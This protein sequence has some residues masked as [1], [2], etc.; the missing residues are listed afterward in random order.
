MKLGIS[1]RNKKNTNG[2][3]G[4][5]VS[6]FVLTAIIFTFFGM[7]VTANL[8]L[9]PKSVAQ[10]S[11]NIAQTGLFPIIDRNG[12]Q[13]SPFV[14]VVEQVQDAVV[15]VSAKAKN[16]D[17]PWWHQGT[18]FS[19]SSGS[20]F[21]FRK[22]G[23]ILT[24]NHVVENAVELYVT[25]ASG[26]RYDATLVGAD[27]QTDLAVVKI[28][29]ED[30]DIAVIEFG[31]SDNLKVGDWA[32]AIGNPFPQ[33]GLDR[34]VTVGVI[35]AKGRRNL[36]F[37]SETPTYQDYIQTDASINPGNSGG[38]LLNL[39]GQCI[40][41]NAA[42]SSPTGG[43][44]GIGFA[45]PIN[46]ARSVVPD[47]IALG[48]VNRGWL[49]VWL[50]ELTEKEARR[51]GIDGLYGVKIDSVFK[52]SPADVAGIEKGDIIVTINGHQVENNNHLSVLVS[53]AKDG[54]PV[55]MELVRGGE[56]YTVNTVV[57]DRDSF[58]ADLRNNGDTPTQRDDSP[59]VRW[60]GMELTSFT[61]D[62][63]GYLNI[64]HID[65]VFVQRVSAGSPADNSSV[66]RG[67]IIMQISNQPVSSVED[68]VTI[69]SNMSGIPRRIPMIVVEPDGSLV[70]KVIRP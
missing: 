20:G 7:L 46:L 14:Q 17:T 5:T 42:I 32:I 58:L 2:Q 54:Q 38:P 21:F 26:F 69:S 63:A 39:K 3:N 34:T 66:S 37:G 35:S 65:G 16:T 11:V 4:F 41:V 30:E 50:G 56:H 12:E 55:P 1:S 68:I 52:N 44:V 62:L 13:E 43:S 36:H 64:P 28:E 53:Q 27:P 70:R 8:D 67:T 33:Q 9:T 59:V 29:V 25:T 24:N 10:V 22:D 15:N 40:G 45:I 49:G 19:T 47:L 60:L 61:E 51:Q 6:L 31:D 57:A 18:V 48:K 23:Y